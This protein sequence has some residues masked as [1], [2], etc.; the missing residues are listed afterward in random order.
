MT[1]LK[2]RDVEVLLDRYDTDPV[3]AL[4]DALRVA[5]DRPDLD[6]T[7]LV[8]LAGFTCARRIRLQAQETAALD[9]LLAEL[10]E[11]RTLSS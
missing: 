7:A 8:K 1:A 2:K 6:F 3:A 10:N 11:M 5:L 9:E 4:T